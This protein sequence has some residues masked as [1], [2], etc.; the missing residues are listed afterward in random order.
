MTGLRL[1]LDLLPVTA[2]DRASISAVTYDKCRS[3]GIILEKLGAETFASHLDP[4]WPE[5]EPHLPVKR[6]AD[7]FAS[8]CTARG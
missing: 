6:I 4:L 2:C 3:D 1:S 8:Y 5:D 7:W